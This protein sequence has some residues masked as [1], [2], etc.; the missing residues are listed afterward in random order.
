M[1]E[2][3][4]ICPNCKTKINVN[5]ILYQQ[6]EEKIRSNYER[7]LNEKILAEK[8][9]LRKSLKEEIEK[10]QQELIKTLKAELEEKS[11]K[12]KEIYTLQ[13]ELEKLK[14][15]KEESEA[16]IKLAMEKKFSERLSE[17]KKRIQKQ[18]EEEIFLKLKDKDKIIEDLKNQLEEAKR[19]A[20]AGS[21]QLKG[22]V[23]EIEIERILRNLYPND[24]ILEVK[25]GQKGADVLQVVINNQGKECG[26][27]YY[28]SKRTKEFNYDWLRKLREDNLEMK[29]D[30]LVLVTETMPEKEDKF[31][32]K[33]GVWIC[34]FFELKPVS[35]I[36]RHFL[37]EINNIETIH[38]GKETKM[39]LLYNYL[40]SNEF[41][42]QFSAIIEGFVELQK[43]YLEERR[44]ME[45]L[46]A[47][48][49]EQ[50]RKILDNAAR[51]YGTIKGIAGKTLPEIELFEDKKELP[52]L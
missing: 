25:K 42:N 37:L 18:I 52:L 40:T 41:K 30:I 33:E 3:I 20:E 8:E 23:Q 13:A 27:I 50:L 39:E 15:E 24:K 21:I 9:K 12:I 11:K 10:E 2:N 46:W 51:F 45:A 19:K 48:R 43:S 22:E 17:E 32:F 31:F 26:K 34:S 36:L 1:N 4:I 5:E 6:I 14:R 44:K 7:K 16:R 38:K 47:K 29:A 28:E 49:E 35:F